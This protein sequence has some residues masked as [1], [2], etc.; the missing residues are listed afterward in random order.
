MRRLTDQMARIAAVTWVLRLSQTRT[1]GPPGS[2]WAAWI[3]PRLSV[4][5]NSCAR[6]GGHLGWVGRSAGVGGRACSRSGPL[7]IRLARA[8]GL[9]LLRIVRGTTQV[10]DFQLRFARAGHA[11]A[12]VFVPLSLVIQPSAHLTAAVE[13]VARDGVPAAAILFPLGL[14]LFSAGPNRTA[15]NR[16]FVL[17]YAGGG[18]IHWRGRTVCA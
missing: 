10:T 4:Q 11:H 14:F 8:G 12:G 17:V 1:I 2:R 5:G 3:R 18:A 6:R 15:P 13:V 16:L 7:P 9:A